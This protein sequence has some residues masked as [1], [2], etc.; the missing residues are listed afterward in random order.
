MFIETKKQKKE[1][2]RLYIDTPGGFRELIPVG[3]EKS[4][5]KIGGFFTEEEVKKGVKSEGK[6]KHYEKFSKKITDEDHYR[7]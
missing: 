1:D 6:T 5:F 7:K 4:T 3:D 2:F